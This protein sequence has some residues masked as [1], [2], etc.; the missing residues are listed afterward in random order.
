MSNYFAP[1][2]TTIFGKIKFSILCK[3]HSQKTTTIKKAQWTKIKNVILKFSYFWVPK[4]KLLK[5]PS[6]AK[7]YQKVM[8]NSFMN[9]WPFFKLQ[10][11]AI[12]WKLVNYLRSKFKILYITW[13]LKQRTVKYVDIHSSLFAINLS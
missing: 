7:P 11:F 5:L 3:K 1:T 2:S 6:M 4:S 13:K 8:Y 12:I 9:L 10:Y